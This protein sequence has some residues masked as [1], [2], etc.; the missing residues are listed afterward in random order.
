MIIN[1]L[2]STG[3]AEKFSPGK[4]TR[5]FPL[6]FEVD[7]QQS[8]KSV[9]QIFDKWKKFE[10]CLFK[11][12]EQGSRTYSISLPNRDVHNT[13]CSL[14]CS[15]VTL[16][17]SIAISRQTIQKYLTNKKLSP[18]E[19]EYLKMLSIHLSH[20][21]GASLFYRPNFT[22]LTSLEVDKNLPFEQLAGFR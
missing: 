19:L 6:V 8:T 3:N 14:L 2:V 22:P 13:K 9:S 5:P 7:Q 4:T 20:L 16:V 1:H 12:V 18:A 21:E 10:I 17:A 11:A 15:I